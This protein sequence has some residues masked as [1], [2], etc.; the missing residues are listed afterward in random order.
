MLKI[1]ID[2]KNVKVMGIVTL[3]AMLLTAGNFTI[4]LILGAAGIAAGFLIK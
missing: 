3:L 1:R 2:W 4:A